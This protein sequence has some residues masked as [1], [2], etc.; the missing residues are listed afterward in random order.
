MNF[1]NWLEA[2]AANAVGVGEKTVF[3]TGVRRRAAQE[4]WKHVCSTFQTEVLVQVKR[5]G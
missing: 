4:Q 3:R 1:Q 2:E 5:D